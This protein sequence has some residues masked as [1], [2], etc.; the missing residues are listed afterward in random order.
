[1]KWE[2]NWIKCQKV[3]NTGVK[4]FFYNHYIF[5]QKLKN[6]HIYSSATNCLTEYLEGSLLINEETYLSLS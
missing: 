2:C 6:Y 3:A 1:M 4:M 5:G